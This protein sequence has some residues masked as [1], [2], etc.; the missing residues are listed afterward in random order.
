MANYSFMGV[1]LSNSIATYYAAN[2]DAASY[3]SY[4]TVT[5]NTWED[6]QPVSSKQRNFMSTAHTYSVAFGPSQTLI[7]NNDYNSSLS[8]PVSAMSLMLSSQT[9]TFNETSLHGQSTT[10]SFAPSGTSYT[11]NITAG[12][13]SSESVSTYSDSLV[14]SNIGTTTAANYT[15]STLVPSGTMTDVEWYGQSS[16]SVVTL[17]NNQNLFLRTSYEYI[18]FT[19]TTVGNNWF[20]SYVSGTT[21][22]HY[23]YITQ[24]TDRAHTSYTSSWSGQIKVIYT[25]GY[26]TSSEYL[27]SNSSITS[28]ESGSGKCTNLPGANYTYLK[29]TFSTSTEQTFT[30][31]LNKYASANVSWYNT[32]SSIYTQAGNTSWDTSVVVTRTNTASTT[33]PVGSYNN[34]STSPATSSATSTTS[35]H[36]LNYNTVQVYGFTS[37]PI[38]ESVSVLGV[39]HSYSSTS[40]TSGVSATFNSKT[41]SINGYG[42]VTLA[43][44]SITGTI[45]SLSK[46][47]TEEEVTL[48]TGG[49]DTQ[50]SSISVDT[51]SYSYQQ[52]NSRYSMTTSSIYSMYTATASVTTGD[53]RTFSVSGY[54]SM[55]TTSTSESSVQPNGAS[56]ISTSL[57]SLAQ[58]VSRNCYT[59]LTSY[60]GS[61]EYT[62]NFD[63][64]STDTWLNMAVVSTSMTVHN[65][66]YN[67]NGYGILKQVSSTVSGST[68]GI[69]DYDSTVQR[70]TSTVTAATN[71]GFIGTTFDYFR[72]SSLVVRTVSVSSSSH[73]DVTQYFGSTTSTFSYTDIN[74]ALG[75]NRMYVNS[76]DNEVY[77]NCLQNE[78]YNTSSSSNYDT[79]NYGTSYRQST[80]VGSTSEAHAVS[81]SIIQN[82]SWNYEVKSMW[83]YDT[84]LST[85]STYSTQL[86]KQFTYSNAST[87]SSVGV[88]SY[89]ASTADTTTSLTGRTAQTLQAATT[90]TWSTIQSKSYSYYNTVTAAPYSM[91]TATSLN[92]NINYTTANTSLVTST[93]DLS[94]ATTSITSGTYQTVNSGFNYSSSSIVA[95]SYEQI[96]STMQFYSTVQYGTTYSAT[97]TASS[98]TSNYVDISATANTTLYNGT[99]ST[100][101]SS[102]NGTTY[103]SSTA[104]YSTKLNTFTSTVTYTPIYSSSNGI[105]VTTL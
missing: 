94:Y 6:S 59:Y 69:S 87:S 44:S 26:T 20:A 18:T 82:Y 73:N 79:V 8:T 91:I 75:Y 38:T 41:T 63:T 15:R 74:G 33:L 99:T 85:I 1:Q 3:T 56:V 28:T 13:D 22:T 58:T 89:T 43:S 19:S 77:F 45:S 4:S 86:K 100:I 76:Y 21:A 47:E 31:F 97:V 39:N 34:A 72:D 11:Q 88:I 27:D 48:A 24:Y 30:S 90:Q 35:G 57:L 7:A 66:T 50:S 52:D 12:G 54:G 103:V 98:V 70:Q 40:Y 16:G 93:A 37:L 42:S 5:R 95:T 102:V 60:T 92:V 55:I 84:M 80:A 96:S 36:A 2:T 64:Y 49:Y 105:F 68:F 61:L 83:S 25:S 51:N 101:Y 29:T 71:F 67:D 17:S 104:E 10:L 53:V 65:G 46:T 23:Q 81:D 14:T 9:S 32:N 62:S 78:Q